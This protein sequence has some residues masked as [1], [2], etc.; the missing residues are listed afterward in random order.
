[1]ETGS[2]VAMEISEGSTMFGLSA[3]NGL[4]WVGPIT[5]KGLGRTLAVEEAEEEE[6]D[7]GE[8]VAFAVAK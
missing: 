6:E 3:D 5:T 8:L 4:E 7:S 1:M 2:D